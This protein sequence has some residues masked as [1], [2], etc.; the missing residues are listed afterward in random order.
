MGNYIYDSTYFLKTCIVAK[1]NKKNIHFNS[2]FDLS[3]LSADNY[4]S[5]LDITGKVMLQTPFQSVIP[6][7]SEESYT[8]HSPESSSGQA[9]QS[10][11]MNISVKTV[12]AGLYFVKIQTNNGE[13]IRKFVKQ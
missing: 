11:K 12:P 13:M 5:I 4:V 10:N 1:K 6:N 7:D 9:I 3:D 8:L 2:N